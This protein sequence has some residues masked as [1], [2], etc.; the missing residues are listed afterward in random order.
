MNFKTSF[1]MGALTIGILAGNAAADAISFGPIDGPIFTGGVETNTGGIDAF[2]GPGVRFLPCSPTDTLSTNICASLSY[3][4]T[5][6]PG[7]T[8][9]LQ[10]FPVD[11]AGPSDNATLARAGGEMLYFFA[12]V[13][14]LSPHPIPLIVNT[15]WEVDYTPAVCCDPPAI[16][17]GFRYDAGIRVDAVDTVG[18][19]QSVFQNIAPGFLPGFHVLNTFALPGT[20][21]D[22]A[23]ILDRMELSNG[24]SVQAGTGPAS[25]RLFVDPIIGFAP[26]FD[27][28]GYSI[29][30]SDGI[31][32]GATGGSA[33]PEPAG[34]L[35][36][37]PGILLLLGRGA[38]KKLA[39]RR[40]RH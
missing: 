17:S 2:N 25:A 11:F 14:P 33:V 3:Q 31:S 37:A 27:S 19:T 34:W 24:G 10:A 16:I 13:G 26:G 28:T 22:I 7:F 1:L 8:A 9:T 20:E 29:V 39:E 32:N 40:T 5:P 35:L 18:S 6:Q 38:R 12:V 4:T 30:V 36:I 21:Y 15:F 23:L